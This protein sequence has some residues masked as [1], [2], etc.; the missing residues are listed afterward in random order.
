MAGVIISGT[1]PKALRPGVKKYTGNY[2]KLPKYNEM[3]FDVTTSDK[4]YEEYVQINN[5]GLTPAKGEGEAVRYDAISQGYTTRLTNVPYAKGIV[6]SREAKA[7]GKFFD[8]LERGIYALTMSAY[9]TSQTLGAAVYNNGFSSSFT[10]GDA[11][12]LFST[13]HP[14]LS[15]SQSNTLSVAADFS[16]ASVEDLCIQIRK[17]KD[18]AGNQ[19]SLMSELLIGAPDNEFEFERLL[20]TTGRVD[21]ANNDINAIKNL[22]KFPKGYIVNPFLSDADAF[23]IKT[24]GIMDGMIYQKREAVEISKD[25]DFDTDNM[26]IK[27]YFR[28]TYLWA[29]WRA[30]YGSPGA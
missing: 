2:D 17:A 16:E 26:K 21:T 11:K 15:G 20:K 9:Q 19:I 27:I 18:S 8:V 25:N 4:G 14:S 23:F 13:S 28:E 5:M 30:C 3:M 12:E 1:I 29:D 22:G 10:G 6:I 7:D 24:S